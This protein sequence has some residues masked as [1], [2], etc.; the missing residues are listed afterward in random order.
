MPRSFRTRPGAGHVSQRVALD[1]YAMPRWEIDNPAGDRPQNV[2]DF[3]AE[4]GRHFPMFLTRKQWG[5]LHYTA[6]HNIIA[7]Q[8]SDLRFK[9]GPKITEISSELRNAGS[10]Y[11]GVVHTLPLQ[12]IGSPI[13]SQN[14]PLSH[15][16]R[17]GRASAWMRV[18]WM[19]GIPTG[20]FIRQGRSAVPPSGLPRSSAFAPGNMCNL[21]EAGNV[22]RLHWSSFL[23]TLSPA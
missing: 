12:H 13:A 4:T 14:Y 20:G 15:R 23:E 9:T 19:R 16:G 17:L 1:W 22:T 18:T 5:L 21:P 2:C 6:A 3:C 8:I 7:V 11:V 10:K